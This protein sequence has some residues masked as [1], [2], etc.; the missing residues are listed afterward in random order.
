MSDIPQGEDGLALSEEEP[1]QGHL[2]IYFSNINEDVRRFIKELPEEERLPE[3]HEN[4]AL[5][6]RDL[7]TV[8][9]RFAPE[10]DA[11]HIVL[12]MPSAPEPEFVQY[13]QTL[14]NLKNLPT[15]LSPKDGSGYTGAD[16]HG[17][18]QLVDQLKNLANEHQYTT[19]IGYAISPSVLRVA[20]ELETALDVTQDQV[21]LTPDT[22][23]NPLGTKSG[24]REFYDD[25]PG[26]AGFV[27]A[28]GEVFK[29]DYSGAIE[30]AARRYISEGAVVIKT[31][32]G[33]SGLGV[34]IFTDGEL[35][36]DFDECVETLE[37]YMSAP[38]W[39]SFPIVV[40]QYIEADTNLAGGNP[41]IEFY[42]DDE[43]PH[44]LYTC[45]MKVSPEG[46]FQGVEVLR[47]LLP[48]RVQKSLER[49][50]LSVA[51]ALYESGY[52][53]HHDVDC[54]IDTQDNVLVS[55]VNT[56]ITGGSHVHY[57]AKYLFG[58]DY[59]DKT[60]IMAESMHR[61]SGVPITFS[62]MRDRLHG[63]LFDSATNAGVVLTGDSEL[64]A[65]N[66]LGYI[67]F[68]PTREA[69]A[70]IQEKMYALVG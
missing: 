66:K 35:K 50:G 34:M 33:H 44:L 53:G 64:L 38:Y 52:R 65:Q 39:Q 42:I 13:V 62:Q 27:M 16:A 36:T 40:E 10:G 3:V 67:I 60:V 26:K 68:A 48:T 1:R 54:M 20:N 28:E 59:L 47:D 69:A 21:V 6:K 31:N 32:K 9:S 15:I 57:L 49:T 43:G 24:L 5:G 18:L 14:L 55:E 29:Q 12:V 7:L 58:D 19:V 45:G 25:N 63:L 30:A 70:E 41:S 11:S 4:I 51:T 8:L 17:D 2:L 46:V 37:Q 61:F 22:G 56:R 23:S